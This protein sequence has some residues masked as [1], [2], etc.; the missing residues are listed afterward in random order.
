MA[1]QPS[2]GTAGTPPNGDSLDEAGLRREFH[3][4]AE[5]LRSAIKGAEIA[6]TRDEDSDA[7]AQILIKALD[8][9]ALPER[10]AVPIN[11]AAPSC[12]GK[13]IRPGGSRNIEGIVMSN[14][15]K[16]GAP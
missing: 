2:C 15:M 4:E 8:P 1:L 13:A 6:I 11:H 16:Y 12:R 9:E 7:A 3:N 10:H 5:R 14:N